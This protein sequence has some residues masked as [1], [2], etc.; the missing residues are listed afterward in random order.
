[1]RSK[2]TAKFYCPLGVLPRR[3]A[4]AALACVL[5]PLGLSAATLL[6][7]KAIDS[8][9]GFSGKMMPG[10]VYRV[11]IPRRDLRVTVQQIPL[12]TALALGGYAVYQMTSRGALIMGDIPLLESEVKPVQDRFTAAGFDIT[13]LHNHL[14]HETPHI[15]YLHFMKLGN[16]V[17]MS[18]AL[19]TVLQGTGISFA[20]HSP[21]APTVFPYASQIDSALNVKGTSH[22]DIYS[23]TVPRPEKDSV[24]GIVLAPAMGVA[25]SINFQTADGNRL[26]TTGDFVLTSDQVNPVRTA[27]VSHGIEVTALHQ[28]LV[29]GDPTLYFMH[30]WAASAP[31]NVLSGLRA[32]VDLIRPSSL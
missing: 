6:D 25:T 14:L 20:P 16:A 15:M 27:L 4:A 9:V 5:M 17:D 29:G 21:A 26:A 23:I 10:E 32:A 11:S 22:D 24:D 28:H 12:K 7:T 31:Q 8:A 3:T 30:F 18:R 19:H 2:I 13:A 1:M